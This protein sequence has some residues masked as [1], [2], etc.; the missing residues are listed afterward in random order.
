MPNG[1]TLAPISSSVNELEQVRYAL[2]Q[3]AIVATTDVPGRIKYVNDKFCEISK[4][5]RH[6]LV[7]QDHRIL[8]SGF[9]PEAFMRGLWRTIA[10]GEIWHGEIRNRAKDG[11][12]Y[13]VDTTIVP[14]LDE[15]G[16]PW[17]YMAIR[18][19]ITERKLHEQR[20]RDQAAL[21]SL[22]EMA[23]VVAHEVRNPLA[24]LRSG[25]QLVG[26]LFPEAGEG[27][28]LLGDMIARLDSLNA[29]VSDLLV[30][31]RVR[32]LKRTPVV[33]RSLVEDV[34]ASVRLDP[35]A[36]GTT[37]ALEA[38]GSATVAIDVD[39]MRIVLMNLVLN[40]AQ[41]TNGEGRVDITITEPDDGHVAI[42]VADTGPGIPMELRERVF[43]PFFSTKHRG[44]GLGL[45]TARRIVEAHQGELRVGDRPGDGAALVLV[46]PTRAPAE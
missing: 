29:V 12:L 7:G 39:Q 19:D 26:S 8:N 34:V 32:E 22:G 20:L 9:H 23:A 44:T 36:R 13:W 6:E 10:N 21:T 37:F 15:H 14:F 38:G 17:Q 25:M 43:E 42:R 35:A 33:L 31:A 40:A 24:G 3:S 5:S 2:D 11:S 46:L 41:A 45:P 27:R 30:F 4:Y 18:F 16:R 28:E 1:G